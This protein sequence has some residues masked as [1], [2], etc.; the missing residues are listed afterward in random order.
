MVVTTSADALFAAFDT[1]SMTF[2]DAKLSMVF[3][4]QEM[5]EETL[6]LSSATNPDSLAP[7]P[8]LTALHVPF[9][10]ASKPLQ[11]LGHVP[12]WHFRP[13]KSLP[14]C[15]RLALTPHGH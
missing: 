10:F 2:K 15:L 1:A 3:K 7:S 13:R 12:R 11:L 6:L 5:M 8:W 9:P 14:L 4:T